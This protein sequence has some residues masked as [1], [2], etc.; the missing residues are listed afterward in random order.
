MEGSWWEGSVVETA[1]F[2]YREPASQS[3]YLHGRSQPPLNPLQVLQGLLASEGTCTHTVPK[4]FMQHT[5]NT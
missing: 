2:S 1:G 4:T 3:H 5:H